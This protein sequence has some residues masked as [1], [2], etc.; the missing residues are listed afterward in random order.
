MRRIKIGMAENSTETHGETM[1]NRN[2]RGAIRDANK[3]FHLF[4]VIHQKTHIKIKNEGTAHKA[5]HLRRH[6]ALWI[7]SRKL[8]NAPEI[9]WTEHCWHRWRQT[10]S[11]FPFPNHEIN[12]VGW[13]YVF[14]P[15]CIADIHYFPTNQSK[16][17]AKGH[18]FVALKSIRF[19]DKLNRP[20]TRSQSTNLRA[21]W[22][23]QK[24]NLTKELKRQAL[25]ILKQQ[26][27]NKWEMQSGRSLMPLKASF[28][29][30][31]S[32]DLRQY[33]ESI[34][35]GTVPPLWHPKH[36]KSSLTPWWHTTGYLRLV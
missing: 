11:V 5:A 29:Q 3:K 13:K 18:S 14:C 20:R 21:S 6:A 23:T 7:I 26:S 1:R 36:N 4:C 27:A 16:I 32:P 24:L 2:K 15:L 12:T 17:P 35:Q 25:C 8:T 9:L 19:T 33:Q 31:V 34:W 28:L 22:V 10:E 30:A